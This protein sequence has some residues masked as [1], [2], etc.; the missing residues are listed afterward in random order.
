MIVSQAEDFDE[1]RATLL[2]EA[3]LRSVHNLLRGV[4]ALVL[5]VHVA[6]HR[7]GALLNS[8]VVAPRIKLYSILELIRYGTDTAISL[9]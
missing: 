3:L 9:V 6:E 7:W 8:T 5:Q 4:G 1:L 2:S